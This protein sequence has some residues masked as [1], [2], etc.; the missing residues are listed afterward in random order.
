MSNHASL[1]RGSCPLFT[2]HSTLLYTHVPEN[3]LPYFPILG[4]FQPFTPTAK[5]TQSTNHINLPCPQTLPQPQPNPKTTV[6]NP[7]LSLPCTNL[8]QSTISPSGQII[9]PLTNTHQSQHALNKQWLASLMPQPQ[10]NHQL[11]KPQ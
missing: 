9:Y 3:S 8:A 10:Q 4:L 1:D 7:P 2:K 5:T 11:T 6:I